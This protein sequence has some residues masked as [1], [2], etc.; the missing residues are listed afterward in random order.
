MYAAGRLREIDYLVVGHITR[1]ENPQGPILGGPALYASLTASAFGYQVGLL[2]SWAEDLD[3]PPIENLQVVN[4]KSEKSTC[5]TNVYLD[6]QRTQVISAVADTLE[7][8]M[9][10]E[11]W[12]RARMVHFAPVANEIMPDMLRYFSDAFIGISLQGWLRGWNSEGQVKSEEWPESSL[13]LPMADA[14]VLSDEDVEGD[15]D[16]IQRMSASVPV[17]VVTKNKAGAVVLFQGREELIE[18]IHTKSV[19]ATGAGDIFS[20]AFFHWMKFCNDPLAAAKFANQVAANSVTRTGIA[21]VP[22]S[23]ELFDLMQEVA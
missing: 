18:G 10:P 11:L 22:S 21:S 6:S 16:R 4:Y 1:D 13:Y 3:L 19:D 20:T 9:V 15:W 2:T 8:Y 5:F 23:D 14:V 12:R 7:F 17:L